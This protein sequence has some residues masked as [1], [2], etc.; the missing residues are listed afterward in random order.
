LIDDEIALALRVG[1]TSHLKICRGCKCAI[2]R[3]TNE[4]RLMRDPRSFWL[5]L[6]SG[7]RLHE[8]LRFHFAAFKGKH[9]MKV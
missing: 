2:V 3:I 6:G 5:P 8:R 7:V 9:P 4:I 1:M